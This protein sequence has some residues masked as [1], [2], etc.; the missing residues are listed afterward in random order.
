MLLEQP[1]DGHGA[2]FDI[3]NVGHTSCLHLVLEWVLSQPSSELLIVKQTLVDIFPAGAIVLVPLPRYFD[4]A[5]FHGHPLPIGPRCIKHLALTQRRQ[6]M[7]HIAVVLPLAV[8]HAPARRQGHRSCLNHVLQAITATLVDIESEILGYRNFETCIVDW[9][10]ALRLPVIDMREKVAG[11]LILH[12]DDGTHGH[13]WHRKLGQAHP[14]VHIFVVD[15]GALHLGLDQ[16][17]IRPIICGG[18]ELS[19]LLTLS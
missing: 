8:E 5:Q 10:V 11:H 12:L 14:F 9:N 7:A 19:Q 18:L 3:G 2:F 1:I 16:F 13:L 17:A 15:K 6:F 4:T